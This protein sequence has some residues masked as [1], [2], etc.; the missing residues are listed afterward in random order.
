MLAAVE[1]GTSGVRRPPHFVYLLPT[2]IRAS[3]STAQQNALIQFGASELY[4]AVKC[5]KQ[6]MGGS[7]RAHCKVNVTKGSLKRLLSTCKNA[8]GCML[9]TSILR[10]GF[11]LNFLRYP[12]CVTASTRCDVIVR[13]YTATH[14][15]ASA[16]CLHKIGGR[17]RRVVNFWANGLAESSCR[18]ERAR[19]GLGR[20][21]EV[22][23]P[24]VGGNTNPVVSW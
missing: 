18:K 4:A 11:T 2:V 21:C 5:V 24:H 23:L 19:G 7:T 3:I 20:C 9:S 1:N 15:G 17:V 12:R 22:L 14:A 6:H 10:L 13:C 8:L 16:F